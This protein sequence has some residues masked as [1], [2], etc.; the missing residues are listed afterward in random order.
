MANVK[1][2]GIIKKAQEAAAKPA[3]SLLSVMVSQKSVQ[4]R[5][6][7]MLGDKAASFLSS[8][9]TVVND[10][11]LLQNADP[12]TVL[13]AAATAASL[14]L[15]ILP[16]LGKAWVVPYKGNAQFQLGYKGA[17]ALAL[18]S[19]KM[20]SIVMTPVYAGEIQNWNRFTETYT[21][22]E[23]ESDE[24]VGYFARFE[25]TNGFAKATY[26]TKEEVI[27]HAKKFSKSYTYASGPWA[28]NF[29]Q[30]ACKT[31]LMSILKTYAPMSVEMEKAVEMDNKV[32]TF[33][34]D[35]NMEVLDIDVE[36]AAT[37]ET[38]DGRVVDTTTGEVTEETEQLFQ[39]D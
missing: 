22:G 31:V 12:R 9:L 4:D 24:I 35:G 26:W 5:F 15:P 33:K 29:D 37:T 30:M 38:S 25:T 11:K 27:A 1:Q 21:A 39:A 17:I 2:G 23:K 10:N 19:G 36:D 13:A 18:R 7:K 14:D 6:E 34:D 8:L 28:S 20:K 3:Q 32:A 16:S